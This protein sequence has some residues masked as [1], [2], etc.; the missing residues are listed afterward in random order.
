MS[1][2]ALIVI[3]VVLVVIAITL[4]VVG[5]WIDNAW[6]SIPYVAA[7]VAVIG[8]IVLV[9]GPILSTYNEHKKTDRGRG[10]APRVTKQ[11]IDGRTADGVSEF[12]DGWGN[13]ATKCV[14][15]GYRAFQTTKANGASSLVIVVDDA[16]TF[17]ATGPR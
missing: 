5:L 2:P 6:S 13:V 7:V 3:A 17:V 12:P 8:A 14:W 15:N 11:Q 1:V 9:L 16:C 10:D 4:A